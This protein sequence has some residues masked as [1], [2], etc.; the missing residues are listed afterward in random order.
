MK[1]TL[2]ISL[3]FWF[4]SPVFGQ[5]MPVDKTTG[6]ITY[7]EVVKVDSV[8][9]KELYN[10]SKLWAMRAFADSKHVNEVKNAETFTLSLAP[11]VETR[12]L[13]SNL[14]TGY[15]Y[16][17]LTIECRDGRYKYTLTDFKHEKNPETNVCDGGNL[18]NANYD[19][20]GLVLNKK[21]FWADI[22]QQAN[23]NIV[24]LIADMKKSIV[25]NAVH[26]SSD[27]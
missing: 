27:W 26:K 11:S 15:L 21:K 1:S 16:Y 10:A 20:P 9:Q 23:D 14:K 12:D 13:N 2:L 3:I 24:A 8:S 22:K 18:E 19:C 6:K 7:T 17:T 4:A 25:Q 5:N